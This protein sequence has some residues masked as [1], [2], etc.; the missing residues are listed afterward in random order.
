M[1]VLISKD[2][3]SGGTKVPFV[4]VRKRIND[5]DIAGLSLCPASV[6]VDDNQPFTITG[7][8][9][10][11]NRGRCARSER[12]GVAAVTKATL[13][14]GAEERRLV[15]RHDN[16]IRMQAG[17]CRCCGSCKNEGS[18]AAPITRR[19]CHLPVAG[20]A[21]TISAAQ[22][23]PRFIL[24]EVSGGSEVLARAV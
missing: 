16:A 12:G 17:S 2:G 18:A 22:Y 19:Q 24:L 13:V 1:P 5:A 8:Q 4:S 6:F 9:K 7:N 21:G 3:C 10:A 23:T 20:A 14:G 11:G 15:F